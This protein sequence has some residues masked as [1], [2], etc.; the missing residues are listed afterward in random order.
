MVIQTQLLLRALAA[1]K[2][3][4]KLINVEAGLRSFNMKM[5]EEINRIVTDRLS[6]YLFCPTDAAINNLQREGFDSFE[7]KIIKSGDVMQD[8]VKMFKQFAQKPQM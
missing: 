2:L 7:C 6:S 5:P 3:D 4:I 8:A 1:S